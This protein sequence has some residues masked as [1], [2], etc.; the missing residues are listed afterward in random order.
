MTELYALWLPI[1]LS[2]VL[3]FVVSSVI[4]MALPWHKNDYSKVPNE[5]KVMDA[6]RPLA[7]PPG[8]YMLPRASSRQ[9]MSSAEFTEKLKKGPVMILKVLPNGPM[10]MGTNLILWFIYSAVVGLLAAYVAGR[11]LPAGATY[12]EVF[13][14]VGTTAFIG[15]AVALWQMSIWYKRAWSTTLKTTMDGLIYALVTA[16]T[17][18]WL[19]PR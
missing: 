16:G 19:W 10:S 18:G 14:F 9:E 4:H 7:I 13:R 2:S 17:F 15:Y 1:L 12:L 6:L 3:V 8:D 11:A 5:D